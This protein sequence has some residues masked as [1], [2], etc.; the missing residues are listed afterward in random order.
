MLAAESHRD[1]ARLLR[2]SCAASSNV[3]VH[4]TTGF[5]SCSAMNATIVLESSPPLKKAPERHVAP[6]PDPD[7]FAEARQLLAPTPAVVAH[8]VERDVP[9]LLQRDALPGAAQQMSGGQLADALVNR[10]RRR[11]VL[12]AQERVDGFEIDLAGDV[13]VRD[14]APSSEA[15]DEPGRR[16]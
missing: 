10:E 1:V 7:S 11:D 5:G 8:I 12:E 2:S 13:G 3:A 16:A 4:A 15:N 6:Q 14:S 9:V